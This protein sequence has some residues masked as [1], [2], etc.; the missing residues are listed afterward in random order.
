MAYINYKFRK[1]E[2]EAVYSSGMGSTLYIYRNTCSAEYEEYISLL[3][4]NGY[5][6]L[7][8]NNN[9]NNFYC[10]LKNENEQINIFY[11]PCD[12][13]VRI[14]VDSSLS[15]IPLVKTDFSASG[16]TAFYCFEN[17]HTL[18]DCGMCLLVQ[19]PDSSFFVVDSGHYF[20]MNDNGRLHKFL[21]ER[22]PECE[23]IVIN[24]W[25]VTHTHTDHIS[26]LSDFLKYNCDDVVI[27]GFYMNL[28][29]DDY[30]IDDWGREEQEADRR[31]KIQL[32]RLN[33]PINK[34]HSGQRLYIRNLAFD[35][36]CTQ[37]DIYPEKIKDFNDSSA[38]VMLC[39]ENTKILI[40]GDASG[41]VS[42]VLEK[43]FGEKLK[44]DIVQ[45]A[46]HGH[47][48]LS[49]KAYEY[50]NAEIALFPVTRIKFSEELPRLA[51]NRKAIE[52]AKKYYISSDGTV[53][54]TLPLTEDSITVLPDETIEDFMKIERLWGYTYTEEYKKELFELYLQN[55]GKPNEN[56]LP[57]DHMGTFTD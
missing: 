14:T 7:Q 42:N 29:P 52:L 10:A 44:C 47:F 1:S 30:V 2:D 4:K 55:G 22:T 19:C 13:T 32:A 11:T 43:R 8:K 50:I 5:H 41:L 53:K 38:V 17:D 39:A 57:V 16:E 9:Y 23:K 46:H 12:S 18:I 56:L 35:V 54:I 6:I 40:S 34:L 48:G 20:Q 25:L 33:I 49:E 51:A 31:F 27:E 26:K 24:G 15:D 36:L 3:M 28:L 37:E 45:V 21:R